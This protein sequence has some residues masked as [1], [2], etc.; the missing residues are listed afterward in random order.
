MFSWLRACV[1][2]LGTILINA[3]ACVCV[4]SLI[5]ECGIHISLCAITTNGFFPLALWLVG[6]TLSC[7][8]FFIP[9][10]KLAKYQS[11]F[12]VKIASTVC[13][14]LFFVTTMTNAVCSMRLVGVHTVFPSYCQFFFPFFFNKK[15]RKRVECYSI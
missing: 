13:F 14:F 7:P 6:I 5:C 9:T 15:K 1:C 4:K 3:F 8:S 11:C 12:F 2:T 10:V